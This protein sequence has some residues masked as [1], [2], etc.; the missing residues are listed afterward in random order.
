MKPL[1]IAGL[2]LP[3]FLLQVHVRSA[4]HLMGSAFA[5]VAVGDREV[6]RILSA[7]RHAL[8]AGV[9]PGMTVTQARRRRQR[10]APRRHPRGLP[11]GPTG[12]R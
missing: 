11:P 9:R 7:S 8:E 5:I 1:R 3:G 4:P 6:P 12:A 2:Y 10:P